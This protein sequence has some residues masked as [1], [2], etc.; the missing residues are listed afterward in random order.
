MKKE[1]LTILVN[2]ELLEKLNKELFQ[3][4]TSLY[5]KK[6]KD[7]KWFIRKRNDNNW[8]DI[9]QF[10]YELVVENNIQ[11]DV[12][13]SNIVEKLSHEIFNKKRKG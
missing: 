3:E 12:L 7:E 1:I 9:K 13:S 2:N 11:L 5:Y 8:D 6:G 10:P 4:D